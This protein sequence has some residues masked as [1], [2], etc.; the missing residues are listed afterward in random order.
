M[1][2]DA[3]M[4]TGDCQECRRKEYCKKMCS[5]A[6]ER[7]KEKNLNAVYN[8]MIAKNIRSR[9]NSEDSMKKELMV[10]E[11]ATTGRADASTVDQV[12]EKCYDMAI[13]SEFTVYAIVSTLCA[14]CRREKASLEESLEKV[15]E[16][17][18]YWTR[19][20]RKRFRF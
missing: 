5:K 11:I 3:W 7:G 19:Q 8:L 18:R 4:D 12:Y 2:R 10:T 20:N 13:H 1:S 16:E 9:A 14:I 6:K 17:M 15:L